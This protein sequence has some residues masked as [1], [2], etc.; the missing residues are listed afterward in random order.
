[1]RHCG[2]L[3]GRFRVFPERVIWKCLAIQSERFS[4]QFL[5][6]F[7]GK[8][9]EIS[10]FMEKYDLPDDVQHRVKVIRLCRFTIWS[11]SLYP[12]KS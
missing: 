1:M 6:E 2:C 5:Q 7:R 9:A 8:M 10:E 4:L 11:S 3:S 12:L